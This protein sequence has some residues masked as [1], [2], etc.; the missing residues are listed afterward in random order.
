MKYEEFTKNHEDTPAEIAKF[1]DVDINFV[2]VENGSIRSFEDT[3]I[4]SAKSVFIHRRTQ[5]G[6]LDTVGLANIPKL[7]LIDALKSFGKF[8][9][10]NLRKLTETLG[11][12][13]TEIPFM[14]DNIFEIQKKLKC[15]F[16]ISTTNNPGQPK[17]KVKK[18]YEVSG[19][20]FHTQ[21]YIFI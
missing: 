15:N 13:D 12:P 5:T 11:L 6:K 7:S 21:S 20:K 8:K 1:F 10:D 19:F 14:M 4:I 3:P 2:R 18:K 16:V 9:C 17:F